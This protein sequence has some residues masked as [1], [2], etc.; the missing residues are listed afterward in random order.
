MK[1]DV[2][3]YNIYNQEDNSELRKL[4]MVTLDIIKIFADICQ[5]HNLR[6]FMVGGTMLGAIRHKG[7]IPWDD[8]VDMGMP[9][10]DYERFM[11]IVHKELPEGYSFLNYKQNK[12]YKRYFSRIV[13]N[14]VK[15]YNNSNSVE[16][17]E[18]AWLDIFPYDGMPEGKLRQKLHFY[19]LTFWRVMYHASCFDELVN[20]NRPGRPGYQRMI[21]HFI[22][23]TKFGH[24]FD[25]YKL[26][27][28][29]EKGLCKYDYNKS[30][31]VVSFFGA[32]MQKEII[33][34]K[35]FG[36]FAKYDFEDTKFWG[37]EH[38][39]IFLRHYYGDYM[40]PPADA[41]KDKHSIRKIEYM[42]A[43]EERR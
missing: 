2:M 34:K 24:N 41:E 14:N 10:P 40:T 22:Q 36:K 31:T 20:L 12:E 38:Y 19:R 3:E 18:N 25:T 33:S 11:K 15:I 5:K 16:I 39:D 42:N 35:V 17:V 9:R 13:N 29:I 27:R 28:R 8:D 7:F 6:Y 4:Q 1:E 43:D 30:S 37:A 23:K 26:M 32:Y 21:I